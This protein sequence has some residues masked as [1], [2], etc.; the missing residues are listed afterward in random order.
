MPPAS[1]H[2]VSTTLLALILGGEQVHAM[3]DFPGGSAEGDTEKKLSCVCDDVSGGF[4]WLTSPTVE[5]LRRWF[6]LF[7]SYYLLALGTSMS[8]A[9]GLRREQNQGAARPFGNEGG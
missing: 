4:P 1:G 9:G 2:L 3:T 5:P 8:R 6:S 7:Y